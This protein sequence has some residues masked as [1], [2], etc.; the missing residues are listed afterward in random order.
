MNFMRTRRTSNGLSPVVGLV[1]ALCFCVPSA[2]SETLSTEPVSPQDN[3][4]S[5]KYL[6]I[7][8]SADDEICQR[9]L[10]IYD[11]GFDDR[12]D[13]VDGKFVYPLGKMTVNAAVRHDDNPMFIRWHPFD[14][15]I[16]D[17]NEGYEWAEFDV[18]NDGRVERVARSTLSHKHQWLNEALMISND[19]SK[20]QLGNS[21]PAP[22]RLMG[23]GIGY[24]IGYL[25]APLRHYPALN[26]VDKTENWP[27]SCSTLRCP[28]FSHRGYISPFKFRGQTY[29]SF[30]RSVLNRPG[31]GIWGVVQRLTSL[32]VADD[33][34]YFDL[35]DAFKIHVFEE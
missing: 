12:P 11:Q 5:G 2:W 7:V 16:M 26:E 21:G 30:F 25:N 15:S 1:L 32:D 18:D 33:V 17:E 4:N 35:N 14:L 6:K 29:L 27:M 9:L 28:R 31:Y 13:M 23:T 3:N 22:I 20:E 8:Y 19:I 34:C 24:P 10:R